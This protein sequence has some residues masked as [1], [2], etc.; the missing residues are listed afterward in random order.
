MVPDT[1]PHI[2]IVVRQKAHTVSEF[3]EKAL[4]LHVHLMHNPPPIDK[5]A[6]ATQVPGFIGHLA[7]A[8]TNFST[9]SYG[10]KGSKKILVELE[11]SEGDGGEKEK[12]WVQLNINATVVGSKEAG[13][14]EE[15]EKKDEGAE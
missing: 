3:K 10:W 7:L 5:P 2:L 6:A 13:K 14:E 9:G 12:V 8:P 11:R 4:P 1:H 15:G